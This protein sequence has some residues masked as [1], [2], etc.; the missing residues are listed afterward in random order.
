M[1]GDR[2]LY[3]EALE[4]RAEGAQ[5]RAKS[6]RLKE[7]S[8]LQIIPNGFPEEH[9]LKFADPPESVP[10]DTLRFFNKPREKCQDVL[11]FLALPRGPG[12]MQFRISKIV[13]LKVEMFSQVFFGHLE[14]TPYF[15][16]SST[17]VLDSEQT[18]VTNEVGSAKD[19]P[20]LDESRREQCS[21]E[22]CLKMFD[23]SLFPLDDAALI[24]EYVHKAPEERA[25]CTRALEM[26][27]REHAVY[28]RLAK[29]QGTLLPHAYGFHQ[30][31]DSLWRHESD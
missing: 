25:G 7:G 11:D 27:Q 2:E 14:W 16:V 22:I 20:K 19:E 8:R 31:S 24:D 4:L 9:Y 15:E 28:S 5:E 21:T 18:Q 10:E 29:Y 17:D 23:F 26:I 1:I 12:V 13:Q 6:L 30:A 3:R